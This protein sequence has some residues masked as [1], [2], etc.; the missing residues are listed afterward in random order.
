MH[1]MKIE[2]IWL[3][4]K[5]LSLGKVSDADAVIPDCYLKAARGTDRAA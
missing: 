3:A 2:E 5:V 4:G 1:G